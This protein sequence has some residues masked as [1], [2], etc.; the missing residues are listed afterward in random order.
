MQLRRIQADEL[1]KLLELY[2]FLNPTDPE[3][4]ID[5]SLLS[6]WHKWLE[7]PNLHY[8]V[9]VE[10]EQLVSSCMLAIVPNLTRG[11][12]P[13]GVIQN[14]VTHPSF[15]GRGFASELLRYANEFA[16][17]RNCYQVLLQTGRPE[18]HEFYR[19]AGYRDDIKTG[20]VAKPPQN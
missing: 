20:F 8:F 4:S 14:V 1:P 5:E 10:A 3:V 9:A 18:T 11:V 6:E 15:R 16:W 12:R 19:R 2:R 17:S 7:D 13:F